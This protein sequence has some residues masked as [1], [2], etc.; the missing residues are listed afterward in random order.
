MSTEGPLWM[1]PA[2]QQPVNKEICV[3]ATLLSMS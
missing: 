2:I 1:S 3:F